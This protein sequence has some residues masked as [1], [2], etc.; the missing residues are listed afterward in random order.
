[1]S[2]FNFYCP[3]LFQNVLSTFV[4]VLLPSTHFYSLVFTLQ[5]G[6]KKLYN[7]IAQENVVYI[8]DNRSLP[9]KL[10]DRIYELSELLQRYVMII[11]T[12]LHN[13]HLENQFRDRCCCRRMRE[14]TTNCSLFSHAHLPRNAEFRKPW[15]K[16]SEALLAVYNATSLPD[17]RVLFFSYSFLSLSVSFLN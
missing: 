1:M 15:Q 9:V 5:K 2:T 12:A 7:R 16:E 14:E 11:F 3:H 10:C 17:Y 13:G 6:A 8:G 4:L